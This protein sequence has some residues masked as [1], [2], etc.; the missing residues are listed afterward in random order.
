M[1]KW[2]REVTG[3]ISRIFVLIY[4]FCVGGP[5][6]V[7]VASQ[8]FTVVTSEERCANKPLRTSYLVIAASLF[9]LD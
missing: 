1:Q 3:F 4:H 6:A 7:V 8:D 5:H 2:V 9:L